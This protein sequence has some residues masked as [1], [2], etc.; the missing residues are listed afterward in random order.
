MFP[1]HCLVLLPLVVLAAPA[2]FRRT[3]LLRFQRVGSDYV[4]FRLFPESACEGFF[5]KKQPL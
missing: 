1:R 4:S 3:D 2:Q 5:V